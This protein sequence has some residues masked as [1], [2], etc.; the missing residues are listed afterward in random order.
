MS[1]TMVSTFTSATAWLLGISPEIRAAAWQESQAAA[2]PPQL[3]SIYLNRLCYK[4][5]LPWLQAEY[6]PEAAAW[7][8]SETAAA[9]WEVVNG[10]TVATA[11][12]RIVVIPSE[13]WDTRYV[14]ISQEWV[15]IPSWSPN[16]YLFAQIRPTGEEIEVWSYATHRALK[17]NAQ[18]NSAKRTYE[19][20]QQYCD[21]LLPA[22]WMAHEIC[23]QSSTQATLPPLPSLT[24][25]Q[26]DNLIQ[27]LGNPAIA[28]PRMAVPFEH[29][30]ALLENVDWRQQLLKQ[31]RPRR[32]RAAPME[33]CQPVQLQRWLRGW[34]EAGWRLLEAP[35]SST[36]A[37]NSGL[38]SGQSLARESIRQVKPLSLGNELHPKAVLLLVEIRLYE[39]EQLLISAQL[40]P[41][42]EH[43]SLPANLSLEIAS[44]TNQRMQV[45]QSVT[46][47]SDDAYI[48]LPSFRCSPGTE[49]NLHVS[50]KEAMAI[51]RF[52]V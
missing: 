12:A 13:S 37:L 52:V 39:K 25:S 3:G 35:A 10:F 51:E 30:G 18:Y 29:W 23:A 20:E 21:R 40:H 24:E 26:A 33:F 38:R 27:R 34:V 41:T 14:E 46:S 31:R 11:Q 44:E 28:F 22:F 45:H 6:W 7:P 48:Q 9:L 36:T 49:F 47:R 2:T 43:G 16:Y 15:D 4:A 1:L 42:S 32:L 19:L 17:A 5:F 50:L 8:D